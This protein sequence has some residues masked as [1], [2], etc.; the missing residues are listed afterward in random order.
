M[1]CRRW[2]RAGKESSLFLLRSGARLF[3][4]EYPHHQSHAVQP[5]P[6]QIKNEPMLFSIK[7]KLLKHCSAPYQVILTR[8]KAQ[9]PQQVLTGCTRTLF[10][11]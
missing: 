9:M 8:F 4:W 7:E 2:S 3:Y 5:P 1:F 11:P 10:L 6:A